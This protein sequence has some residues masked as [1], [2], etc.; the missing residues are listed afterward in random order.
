[1]KFTRWFIS[2]IWLI[3]SFGAFASPPFDV[4]PGLVVAAE[5]QAKHSD[6]LFATSG[7]VG[8]GLSVDENGQGYIVVFVDDINIKG[9]P[10]WLDGVAVETVFT[11]RFYSLAPP[12][13]GGPPSQRPPECFA[14]PDPDT[15]DPKA[16]FERPVPIGVSTGHPSITAGT[17]GARVSDGTKVYALSNNHVFANSNFA[18]IDDPIIQP[19]TADGGSASSDTYATLAAFVPIKFGEGDE[20]LNLMDAAIALTT[21]GELMNSTPE[22]GYGVPSSVTATAFVGQPV[23]KYGRTTGQTQGEVIAVN[24]SVGV[25]YDSLCNSVARFIQQI[26]ISDGSFSAGGDS[27]SLI[28]SADT[29]EP[30]ALLFAGSQTTTIGSPIGLVLNAFNVTIDSTQAPPPPETELALSANGYKVKGFHKV[31]LEWAGSQASEVTIY[32]NGQAIVTM[33]N[34]DV[35]LDEIDSKGGAVYTHQVCEAEAVEETC[36]NTVVTNF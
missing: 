26:T 11:G 10:K 25:C 32:R 6:M 36:S 8:H 24:S 4:P 20:N 2:H 9:T 28:V 34:V 31:N 18:N 19:G 30:V 3:A 22:D 1:M 13:C 12:T 33:P 14:E 5:A 15:V 35:Y 21:T 7:V 27:G 16:R 17:I 29:N 23:K